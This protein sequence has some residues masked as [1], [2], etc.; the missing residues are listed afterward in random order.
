VAQILDLTKVLDEDLA[1]YT[2]A[3]YSDPPLR[4]K[5]WCTVEQ[6]GF[7]VARLSMGTQTGT[8]IDAPAHFAAEGSTLEALPVQALMGSYAWV[9]LCH[10]TESDLNEL[11]AGY[12]GQG[13]LFLTSSDPAMTEVSGEVL[14]GLLELPCPVW[15]SVY[16]VQVRQPDAFYFHRALSAAGR[17][18][19]EDV[20]EATARQVKPGG[21][22][23][24]LPLR[25]TG[26]SGSPCRVIVAQ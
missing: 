1:I 14:T 22:M 15:L 17:Y 23:I 6:R 2:S 19:I 25:L 21:E 13:I 8:H 18:L 3:G 12:K 24:A 9:D 4:I 20:D 7:A 5:T 10:V 26:V 16:S 11:R